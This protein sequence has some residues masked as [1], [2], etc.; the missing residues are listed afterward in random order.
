MACRCSW[1]CRWRAGPDVTWLDWLAIAA[2]WLPFD[3]GLLKSIWTW[4]RGDGAYMLNTAMAIDLAVILFVSLRGFTGVS[5][6]FRLTMMDLKLTFVALALFLVL[7]LP[8]GYATGFVRYNAHFE[9]A[10]SMFTAVGLLFMVAIPEELLF[11][12]LVQNLLPKAFRTPPPRFASGVGYLWRDASEQQQLPDWRYF[13]L[14]TVAGLFYGWVY[15]K[16]KSLLA[17]A[18]L[19]AA[20]DT[21]WVLFLHV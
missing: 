12:G 20:V 4:P 19:H 9:P 8:F 7:A 16:S 3:F 21:I 1:S 10:R 15:A 14:A 5:L 17:P 13:V 2:I 6:R 18:L 11:R